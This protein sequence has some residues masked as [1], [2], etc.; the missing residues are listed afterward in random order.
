MK[1]SKILIS[2]GIVYLIYLIPWSGK[3]IWTN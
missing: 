2:K 1:E 3:I